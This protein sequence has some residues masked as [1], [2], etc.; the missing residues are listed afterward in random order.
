[1]LLMSLLSSTSIVGLVPRLCEHIRDAGR[2]V[3]M[4]NFCTSAEVAQKLLAKRFT[5]LATIEINKPMF[6]VEFI[7]MLLMYNQ[8][9]GG[10][11]V[12]DQLCA[13]YNCH[14][15]TRRWPMVIFYSTIN[16]IEIM[17]YIIFDSNNG[18]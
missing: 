5:I 16:V 6:P 11:D 4:D 8:T 10:I 13:M 7:V 1:M 15:A 14:R 17:P 3:T 18:I 2:N 9:K 12:V